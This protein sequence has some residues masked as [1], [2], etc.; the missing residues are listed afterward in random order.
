MYKVRDFMVLKVKIGVMQL[1]YHYR[2]LEE[3]LPILFGEDQK[4][5]IKE[6]YGNI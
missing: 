2:N 6:K 3:L 1:H 4:Q 5:C